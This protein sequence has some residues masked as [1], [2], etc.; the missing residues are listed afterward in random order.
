VGDSRPSRLPCGRA[1]SFAVIWAIKNGGGGRRG[2]GS[3]KP[4][5][6]LHTWTF[7]STHAGTDTQAGHGSPLRGTVPRQQ[8]SQRSLQGF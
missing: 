5:G 6:P 1:G 7:T 3:V 4:Q 8:A 2:L